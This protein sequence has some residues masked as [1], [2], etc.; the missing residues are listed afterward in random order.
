MWIDCES[1]CEMN[2]SSKVHLAVIIIIFKRSV[3]SGRY[4]VLVTSLEVWRQ[5]FR[6][7]SYGHEV[8]SLYSPVFCS[9]NRE[10]S[11]RAIIELLRK[12]QSS[13]SI[14]SHEI[15]QVTAT[16]NGCRLGNQHKSVNR[17]GGRKSLINFQFVP[18]YILYA[19]GHSSFLFT[20]QLNQSHKASS[21]ST[22]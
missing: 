14:C 18:R 4:L 3:Q 19:G 21:K 12:Y 15:H 9:R 22:K 7:W 2:A 16:S 11:H 13:H 6:L 17:K 5:V 1:L 10:T 20:A 8:P